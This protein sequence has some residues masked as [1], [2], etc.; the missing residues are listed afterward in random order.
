V[1]KLKKLLNKNESN[2]KVICPISNE[3]ISMRYED[4]SKL[5]EV[6]FAKKYRGLLYKDV[7]LD[8]EGKEYQIQA[9]F[10]TSPFCRWHGM[11]QHKYDNIKNGVCQVSCRI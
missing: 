4:Y 6:K 1:A 8:I 7:I 11:Q 10:C 3:E 2:I 5:E 9:N